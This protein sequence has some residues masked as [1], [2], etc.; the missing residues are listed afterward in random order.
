MILLNTLRAAI[1]GLGSISFALCEGQC[2]FG[3]RE[4]Q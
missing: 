1:T 4:S 2:L 3:E